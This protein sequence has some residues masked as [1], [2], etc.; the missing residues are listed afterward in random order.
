MSNTKYQV[1]ISSTYVDLIE[2]RRVVME[3]ILKMDCIPAGMELFP[4]ANDEQFEFIKRVIDD[5][6][7]YI[8]I[9][10]G[11][12]GSSGSDGIGYTEKE[13]DYAISKGIPVVSFIH[14]DPGNLP[15]KKSDLDP[16]AAGKLA[17]FRNKVRTGRLVNFWSNKDDLGAKVVIGL[18]HAIKTNKRPGWNRG[19]SRSNEDLLQ[20]LDSLR[21]ENGKM[22]QEQ[23]SLL[24]KLKALETKD[25]TGIAGG[26]DL[27]H[28]KGT[29]LYFYKSNH[30]SSQSYDKD[31]EG[32]ISWNE[33]MYHLHPILIEWKNETFVQ[34]HLA[35]I[36]SVKF[37]PS[38]K[39]SSRYKID[40]DVFFTIRNQL[41]A[42]NLIDV[43]SLTTVKGGTA[44]FWKTTPRGSQ[45]GSELRLVKK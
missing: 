28:V 42:L 33:I 8:I 43:Q 44:L 38:S 24:G 7:Y 12:Y 40:E 31:W 4:A 36:F 17:E 19:G 15:V 45:L 6:D 1:F 34:G 22:A 3:S 2:E 10:G 30:G 20:E 21:T 13:F 18:I 25:V 11:R 37:A 29:W 14:E 23:S 9:L 27:F 5:C 39:S 35:E 41:M 16:M 26:A 32:D